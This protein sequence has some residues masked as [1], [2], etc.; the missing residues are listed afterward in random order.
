MPS[1]CEPH[2]P[3][4]YVALLNW[5]GWGDS[6]ECLE[7]L[8]RCDY[9]DYRVIVCDNRSEDGSVDHLEAW[10]DGRLD[11]AIITRAPTLARL[12]SP[13][14]PKPIPYVAYG[15]GAAEAGGGARDSSARLIVIDT[16]ANLGFAGGCNR[17]LRYAL[18]RDD[19]AYVWLLNNDT[20]VNADALSQLVHR[21]R[22]RPDAGICGSTLMYYHAPETIQALGGAQYN[23]WLGTRTP[24][25]THRPAS[26][27]L[28]V[29]EVEKKM[30]Y[31]SG[32]SMLVSR[33]FLNEIGLLCEDYFLYYEEID[34]AMRARG[35]YALAYAAGSIVYHKEG[36]T[37][38]SPRIRARAE[39]LALRNRLLF[40]R[41]RVPIAFPTVWLGLLGVI[42]NRLRRGQFDRVAKI[43]RIMLGRWDLDYVWSEER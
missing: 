3:R 36:G 18:A 40:T 23:K 15:R 5:N 12:S 7:S 16:G 19:F 35:R 24:I 27:P 34:W 33:E 17:A 22:E 4:V 28:E 9:P 31:V 30:S 6:L 14:V 8:L 29:A 43:L 42:L 41:K 2:S 37:I 39:Y 11:V 13:P 25:G 10:A 38:G 32:A 21:M 20:V 26:V 1:A